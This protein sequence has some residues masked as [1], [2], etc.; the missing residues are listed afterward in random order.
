MK[1]V[2][3]EVKCWSANGCF[4]VVI[5]LQRLTQKLIPLLLQLETAVTDSQEGFGY[6]CERGI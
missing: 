1:C 5:M 6:C 4:T 3:N 2:Q